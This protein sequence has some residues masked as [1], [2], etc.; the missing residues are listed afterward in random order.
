MYYM[1]LYSNLNKYTPIYIHIFDTNYT[2][3]KIVNKIVPIY[4]RIYIRLYTLCIIYTICIYKRLNTKK[5]ST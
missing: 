1:Y 2:I 4:K 3:Y 5:G